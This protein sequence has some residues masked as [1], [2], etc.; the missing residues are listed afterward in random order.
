MG[1]V[2]EHDLSR[3]LDEFVMALISSACGRER[4]SISDEQTLYELGIDSMAIVALAAELQVYLNHEFSSDQMW[5]LFGATSIRE[6]IGDL[7]KYGPPA[8]RSDD[9]SIVIAEKE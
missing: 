8:T 9:S 5:E 2:S 3:G 4:S 7:R 6:L 1:S